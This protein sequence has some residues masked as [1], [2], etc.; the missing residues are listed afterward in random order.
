MSKLRGTPLSGESL[1]AGV[2]FVSNGW[3]APLSGGEVHAME[4]AA[5]WAQARQVSTTMPLWAY[6]IHRQRLGNVTRLGPRWLDEQSPPR[7]LPMLC[8]RYLTRS[9]ANLQARPAAVIASSHYPFDVLPAFFIAV[10]CRVPFAAYLF[11]LTSNYRTKGIKAWVLR[12]WENL[13]LRALRHARV[14]FVENEGD[15]N[16]LLKRGFSA[17]RVHVTWNASSRPPSSWVEVRHEDEV[18]FCGRLTDTKGWR[19]LIMLGEALR[20]GFPG[21]VLRVLGDGD[22]KAELLAAVRRTQLDQVVRIEGFVDEETKWRALRR[23]AVFVA[24]SREEGWGI[25]V[26]EALE[27]GAP[28]VCYDLPIYREIHG[29]RMHFVPLADTHGFADCVLQLLRGAKPTAQTIVQGSPDRKL[30][31]WEEIAGYESAIFLEA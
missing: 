1:G 8:L 5:Q 17:S 31:T 24:P 11:H 19:D 27:A 9:V 22:R 21:A 26:A 4:V 12:R 16:E 23:A 25:G 30:R 29:D 7:S 18:V 13:G 15:R 20:D 28:V 14:V 10:R 6:Q 2:L 3:Y